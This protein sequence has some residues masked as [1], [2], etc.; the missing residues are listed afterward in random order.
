MSGLGGY[1][2]RRANLEAIREDTGAYTLGKAITAIL[3]VSPSGDN[4]DGSSFTKAYQ[5]IQAALDIASRDSNALT[6]ILIGPHS[7]YYD[8]NT[9]GDPTWSANVYLVGTHP[10]FARIRNDHVAATA[11]LKLTGKSVVENLLFDLGTGNNGLIM[12]RTG[13][14]GDH[15][16]IDG[17]SLTSAKT[18]IWLDGDSA[19]HADLYQ[20]DIV[21]DVAQLTGLKV[22]QFA[23][24]HFD[25]LSINSCLA[26]IQIV[27]ANSNENDFHDLTLGDSA[28]GIDIDAGN[29]QHFNRIVFHHNTKNI[30]DEVGDSIWTNIFGA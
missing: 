17:T 4:S 20:I 25:D 28:I 29:E 21:G 5:T 7:T 18:G 2:G 22:D 26:G 8:I 23:R 27:G 30:D 11:I 15:L 14:T 19:E 6:L 12:T 3:R 10:H 9:A 1:G 13:V 16:H 24:C